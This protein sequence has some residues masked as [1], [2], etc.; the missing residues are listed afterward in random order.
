MVSRLLSVCV[1]LSV[2]NPVYALPNNDDHAYLL[3][4]GAWQTG[5]WDVRHGVSESVELSSVWPVL[6]IRLP[7]AGVKWRFYDG[8]FF[9][10]SASTALFYY[11]ASMYGDGDMSFT[12]TLIP[13]SLTGTW[14]L[15]PFYVSANLVTT[16]IST[17][18]APRD[19]SDPDD[20]FLDFDSFTGALNMETTIFRPALYWDRGDGFAWLFDVTFSLDQQIAA[21]GDTIVRLR[22]G[23]GRVLGRG[24]LQGRGE[25]DLSARRARNFSVSALWYWTSFH[26]KLGLSMGHLMIPY[27]NIFPVDENNQPQTQ[28]MPK[29]DM[30]WRF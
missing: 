7:N 4:D 2:W 10:A 3:Q 22:D 27:L 9:S 20:Q 18:G 6:A 16:Q 28:T 17:Q 8:D 24:V 12:S 23:S 19:S 15:H 26:L 29:F 30:Y 5:L 1:F 14:D 13:T 21:Q 11:D 25:A